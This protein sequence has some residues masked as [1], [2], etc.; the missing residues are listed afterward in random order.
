MRHV[1]VFIEGQKLDLFENESIE[2]ERSV[3]D[4]DDLEALKTD[5]SYSFAVPASNV[6]NRIF[7][8]YYLYEI[9]N[10]F[11]A[12]RLVE[13]KIKLSGLTFLN[14]R[15]SLIKVDLESKKPISY[16]INF[17][18][19]L[20]NLKET[21]KDASLRDLDFSELDYDFNISNSIA[22]LNQSNLNA[23]LKTPLTANRQLYYNS[24]GEQVDTETLVNIA[25]NESNTIGLNYTEL[26]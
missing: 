15:L 5:F 25:P 19:N 21:Y 22:H 10:G 11:D 20:V 12:R 23:P 4:V 7:K 16:H 26:K 17:T 9:T 2:I 3:L 18:A 24:N 1:D 14:G 13:S 8:H 6:N